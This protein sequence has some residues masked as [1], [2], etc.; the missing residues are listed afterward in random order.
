MI[1]RETLYFEKVGPENT[2]A[3]QELLEKAVAEGYRHLVVASTTGVSGAEAARRLAGK[4]ANLV[5]VGHSVGFKGPNLDE[6]LPEHYEE[7]TRLGGKV[8]KATILTHSLE[9]AIA[10]QFKGSASH[11]VD[12]QYPAADGAGL[13]GLLRDRHGGGGCRPGP[14]GGG[15]GGR[16]RHRPGLGRGGHYSQRCLQTLL[17]ALRPGNLGQAPG[18]SRRPGSPPMRL[19]GGR[20]GRRLEH[21]PGV[22][23]V[24]RLR[25]QALQ[26]PAGEV[27]PPLA[28]LLPLRGEILPLPG[29]DAIVADPCK[30]P[31]MIG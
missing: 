14:G 29:F 12:R 25:G 24:G 1:R 2:P 15:S 8:L 20:S 16:R 22:V 31:P 23:E 28:L 21:R 27:F 17:A 18:V 4:G 19:Q 3:C 6:F 5:V 10:D 26:V 7:I 30:N 11:P 9:T 13:Q